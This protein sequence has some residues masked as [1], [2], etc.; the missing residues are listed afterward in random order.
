MERKVCCAVRE[1]IPT[2]KMKGKDSTH[3]KT[4]N[5]LHVIREKE[6]VRKKLHHSLLMGQIQTL[7]ING[8]THDKREPGKIL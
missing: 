2:R 6:S 4:R 3:G 8:Q 1:F 7:A 5:I